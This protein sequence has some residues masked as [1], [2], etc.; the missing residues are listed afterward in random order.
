MQIEFRHLRSFLIVAEELH[1]GRAAERLHVAQPPLS[2]QIRRLEEELGAELFDRTKRPIRLTQA[3]AAFLEDAQLAVHHTENAL[4]RGRRAAQGEVGQ[5]AIGAT[6]WA[7]EAIVP[8]TLREFRARAPNVGLELSSP[9]PTIQVDALRKEQLD[10]GFVAFARWLIGSRV[11]EVEPL[12][13]EPMV[14][15]VAAGHP[16]ARRPEVSIDELAKERFVTLSHAVAPGLIDRQMGIFHERGVPPAAVQVTTDPAAM[17]SLIA[18]D[19]AVGMH[20]ASFSN[21]RRRDVAFVPIEGDAPTATLLLAWRRDD[22]RALVHTFLES[23]RHAARSLHPPEVFR[24]DR[25]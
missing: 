8:A 22:D 23:A 1:F 21:Q 10:V 3:G 9:G 4:E 25:N 13:E 16:L 18:A 15:I 7:Q 5:L 11:L 24:Q 12:L 17:F 20:M 14:A 2:Q 19:E 6:T